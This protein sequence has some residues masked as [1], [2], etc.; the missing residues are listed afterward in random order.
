[1]SDLAGSVVHTKANASGGIELDDDSEYETEDEDV[2]YG[3]ELDEDEDD[4]TDEDEDDSTDDDLYTS[5]DESDEDVDIG[6]HGLLQTKLPDSADEP[7]LFNKKKQIS[8]EMEIV[9]PSTVASRSKSKPKPSTVAS[10]SKSK[11]KPGVFQAMKDKVS[12]L[13]T[14]ITQILPWGKKN[15]S[16]Y[17]DKEVK[18]LHSVLKDLQRIERVL[19]KS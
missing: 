1:M 15:D 10:R 18:T 14:N 11:P 17:S 3:L 7:E 12:S 13:I 16:Y 6:P 9:E 5:E 8:R 19:E 2:N 4:S